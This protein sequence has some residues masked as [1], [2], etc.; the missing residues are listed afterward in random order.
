MF[1]ILKFVAI[2]AALALCAACDRTPQAP[3]V[4]GASPWPTYDPVFLADELG[5]MKGI[6]LHLQGLPDASAV[7]QAMRGNKIQLAA[8]SLDRALML[9]RDIPSLKVILVFSTGPGNRVD[10]LVTRDGSIGD[11]HHEMHQFL[12]AWRKAQEYIHSHPKQ[13]LA[14]MARHAGIPAAKYSAGLKGVDAYDYLRNQRALIGEPLPIGKAFNAVQRGLLESGKLD[15]GI[16]PAM[17]VDPTLL[18]ESTK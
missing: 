9:R 7:E 16:D 14:A 2:A 12:L 6:N 5:Y 1:R 15:I 4:F 17:L 13:A 11:Y 3:M 10:V 8:L 18:A